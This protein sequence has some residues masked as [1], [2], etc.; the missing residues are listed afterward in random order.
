MIKRLK[1]YPL[2]YF[3][4]LFLI[5]SFIFVSPILLSGNNIGIQDWDQQLAYLESARI[6]VVNF[7]QFPFWNPYHCGG[8]PN[9]ANPQSN[10]ISI[11][12]LLVL[13]F[14]TLSGVKISIF[15]HYFIALLGFF[16]L[17]RNFKL[18]IGPSLIASVIFAFGGA[19]SSA[20]GVGMLSFIAIAYI[21]FVLLFFLRALEK[22]G[23]IWLNIF[24]S[25]IFLALS[26][27]TGYQIPI[28]F[29]PIFFAY[30]VFETLFR[31]RFYPF[32]IF[33][34]IAGLSL[35]FILPKLVLGVELISAY[36]R[37]I[38]DN[39]GYSLKNIFYLIFYL[40]QGYI[41]NLPL[42]NISYGMDENSLYV[43]VI[44]FLLFVIGFFKSVKKQRSIILLFVM[45]FLLMVGNV[46]GNIS[47]WNFLKNFPFYTSFRVAQRFRFDFI[48]FFA[49][50]SGF[51]FAFVSKKFPVNFRKPVEILIIFIVFI[52]LLAVSY[53]SFLSKAFIILNPVSK[54]SNTKFYSV[55]DYPVNYKYDPKVSMPKIFYYDNNYLP[56]GSE[57]TATSNNIGTINCYEPIPVVQ[58]AVSRNSKNYKEEIYLID[59]I[60]KVDIKYWSPDKVVVNL[61]SKGI[62][63][64][65]QN[66]DAHWLVKVNGEIQRSQ[67][68]NGLVSYKIDKP[69][70]ITFFYNPFYFN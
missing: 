37:L 5:L 6:S 34:L 7:G 55:T 51:G 50:L 27:Y 8:M 12:F 2:T 23:K 59:N 15:I 11:T 58:N 41:N 68:Y 62:L 61:S 38:T 13:F 56:W 46:Y 31:K 49:L 16:L 42:K 32:M 9:F 69:Q 28:I 19:L 24:L 54:I 48:I 33:I 36:P 47:I 20:L 53:S 26:F 70:E 65:N 30:S 29:L 25:S 57:Y 64:M 43:G 35:L 40:N 45:S 21:P 60:G 10:I 44:P 52:N 4:F 3:I 1:K 22:E 18:N 17:S 63:V 67:Q 39:S 66:Y 14:G